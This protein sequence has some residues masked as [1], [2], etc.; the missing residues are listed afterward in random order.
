[1]WSPTVKPR[2]PKIFVHFKDKKYDA[3]GLIWRGSLSKH[4]YVVVQM[5]P[6][7]GIIAMV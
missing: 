5:K 7:H 1:M 4:A 3:L 2:K 6:Q